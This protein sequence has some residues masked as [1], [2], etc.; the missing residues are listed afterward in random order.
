MKKK[1]L[2]SE[3]WFNNKNDPGSTAIYLERYLNYGLKKK[4]LQWEQ[5]YSL[6][7]TLI[8]FCLWM[9]SIMLNILP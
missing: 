2:R 9:F 1:I 6:C 5:V 4:D 3:Y 8:K 7:Q